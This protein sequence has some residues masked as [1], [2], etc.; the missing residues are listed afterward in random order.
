[1]TALAT[2][3]PD[4]SGVVQI[5]ASIQSGIAS[6][7]Q[8]LGALSGGGDRSPLFA[9]T[10][11]LGDLK[12]KVIVDTSKLSTDLPASLSTMSSSLAPSALDFVRTIESDF[13]Q[14]RSV[15]ADSALA[16]AVADGKSLQDVALAAVQDVLQAFDTH[17]AELLQHI[18]PGEEL[19]QLVDL[20]TLLDHLATDYAAHSAQLLPFV[21]RYLVGH[22]PDLLAPALAHVQSGLQVLDAWN[23]AAV[24]A[25]IDV[26][27]TALM[28]A[29]RDLLQYLSGFDASVEDS[30]AQLD[31]LIDAVHAALPPLCTALGTVYSQAGAAV[32]AHAWDD[33]F[34]A[35]AALLDVLP[36]DDV[37]VPADA[38]NALA[39][40]LESLLSRIEAELAPS[41]LAGRIRALAAA[42]HEV[43]EQS[44]LGHVRG[45]IRDFLQ[46]IVAGI[47][48]I[49]TDK[50][51]GTVHDMLQGIG[52]RIQ[53][54]GLANV[55]DQIESAFQAVETFVRERLDDAL[56]QQ[57]TSALQELVA[58]LDALPVETLVDNVAQLIAQLSQAITALSAA[59]DDAVQQLTDLASQL[60]DLSFKPVG[61]AVV[62]EIDE[63]RSRLAA[64]NPNAMSDV[65]KLALQG[66]LAIVR[67]VDLEGIVQREVKQG[68]G[69][70]RD[71]A[72]SG[73]DQVGGVLDGLREQVERFSPQRLV[74]D[75][76]NVLEEARGTVAQLD[77]RALMR[78]L[79][80]EVDKLAG[81]L[82][83]A[84]PGAL[85]A[86]LE[87]PYRTVVEGVEQL[88]PDR[89]V[90]PLNSIYARIDQLIDKVNVVPLLEELDR[91]EKALLADVRQAIIAGLESLHL[92]APL[93]SFYALI[94]PVLEGLT[95]ALLADPSVELRRVG[96]DLSTR[97]KPSDLF[98]P[99]DSAFAQFIGMLAAIPA[100]DIEAAFNS[101]RTGLGVGLDALDPG[102]VTTALRAGRGQLAALSPRVLMS[103]SLQLPAVQARFELRVASV[104]VNLQARVAATRAR[105]GS[106][107][108]LVDG[109]GSLVTPLLVAHDGL[110][111]ALGQRLASL[112]SSGALASYGR[113]NAN[114]RRLLPVFL[115]SPQPL[116]QA[117]ILS[118][119]AAMRPSSQAGAL[120]AL[121]ARF[122]SRVKSMQDVLDPAFAE[123]FNT[124][125]EPLQALS[126]LA[127]K[128]DVAAVYEALH[129]KVRVIDPAA[130]ATDLH[131]AIY[132]PVH[133]ALEA[134][135]PAKLGLR[136]DAA[137]HSALTA[138]TDKVRALLDSIGT[139]LDSQLQRL[140]GAVDRIVQM[141]ESALQQAADVFDG[142][143]GTI[144]HLVFVEVL[145][146]LRRLVRTLGVSFER[147][148]D[149]VVSA[150]DQMLN[151]IPLGGSAV[152]VEVSR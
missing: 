97:F 63:L 83:E 151:A 26:P 58:N 66:A 90:E 80:G 5:G 101:L 96:L 53:Q 56:G 52:D 28:Q 112:D 1:M 118:G 150:F 95:E 68:F 43:F 120:D 88:N 9:I 6:L 98:A 60:D 29:Q 135:D 122:Q 71:A 20:L 132:D 119:L 103:T 37:P 82:G 18:V 19:G 38:I 145:E 64:M 128:D 109:D 16:R 125:R 86:P 138:V 32:Q 81:L 78:P 33:V 136:L 14:A 65:E 51:S 49:P 77:G 31:T 148:V 107:V 23:G 3:L 55:G 76:V 7:S 124:L 61:D 10:S 100:A 144:E 139:A 126:P 15:I 93:D 130:L 106:L 21:S 87:A 117:D 85:L 152:S 4:A 137:Y 13:D 108:A 131:A 45:A 46:Q 2:H 39:A 72:L 57:V 40:V 114:L 141:I 127:I 79:Y 35:Y 91:R 113:V 94:K 142:L 27:S 140:R 129:A 8:I 99:L 62:G 123:F 44:P 133:A 147:E 92:P 149:R 104:P 73:L 134:V 17:R 24:Q 41:D 54:L 12:V 25:L 47:E 121:F 102:R 22:G 75:L 11:T 50:I 84:N 143:V 36:L 59:L 110:D 30:Y 115:F 34:G 111:R 146:R 42:L 105:L 70:A 69:I 89:L 67:A 116:T 48:A 74:Q